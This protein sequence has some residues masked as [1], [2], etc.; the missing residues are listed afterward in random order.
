[1]MAALFRAVVATGVSGGLLLS[2]IHCLLK[3]FREPGWRALILAGVGSLLVWF[4]AFGWLF[5]PLLMAKIGL[6]GILY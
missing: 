6:A 1:M 2:G 4:G 3:A 5:G